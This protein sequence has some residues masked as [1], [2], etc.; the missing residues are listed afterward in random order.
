[1]SHT[2]HI[3][4]TPN[5]TELAIPVSVNEKTFILV[6]NHIY[7]D[8]VIHVSL[9]IEPKPKGEGIVLNASVIL[10]RWGAVNPKDCFPSREALIAS[11]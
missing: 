1:M 11:L 6:D 5:G 8:K 10:K 2:W 7:E 4:S 9:E 3:H